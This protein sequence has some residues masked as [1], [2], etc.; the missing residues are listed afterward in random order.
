LTNNN[1][2]GSVTGMVEFFAQLPGEL[3]TFLAE[4]R[5]IAPASAFVGLVLTCIGIVAVKRRG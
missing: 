5:A 3:V 4:H 2:A 1:H